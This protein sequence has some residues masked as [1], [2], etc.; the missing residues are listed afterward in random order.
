MPNINSPLNGCGYLLTSDIS[1][2]GGPSPVRVRFVQDGASL[3]HRSS[4]PRRP[5]GGGL[6]MRPRIHVVTLAVADLDRALTFYRDGMGFPTEGLIGTEFQADEGTPDGA[7]AVFQLDGGLMLSVYPRSELAKNA[8]VPLTG[9]KTGE[10]ASGTS[11]PPVTRSTRSSPWPKQPGQ[12]SP[13]RRT[14]GRG[15]STPDISKIPT[16]TCGRSSGIPRSTWAHPEWLPGKAAAR[17]PGM[18]SPC[19]RSTRYACPA[20]LRNNSAHARADQADTAR[21]RRSLRLISVTASRQ[22][23]SVTDRIPRRMRTF[24]EQGWASPPVPPVPR[25]QRSG[26]RAAGLGTAQCHGLAA[27]CAQ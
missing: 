16:A 4:E 18:R 13:T 7:T 6:A 1:N 24:S 8:G 17:G 26:R 21:L 3:A 10:S 5:P 15:A 23:P 27:R 12:P 14:T 19:S 25:G 20:A 9:A 2:S 11:L 22:P